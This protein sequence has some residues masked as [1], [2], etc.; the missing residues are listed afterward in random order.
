MLR[1][2]AALLVLGAALACACGTKGAGEASAS[3]SAGEGLCEH[4]VAE[5]LCPKCH[6]ELASVY[7]SNGD[8]CGEH[9][10]PESFCP[11]CHPEAKGRPVEGAP[12][13]KADGGAA[14][15]APKDGTRVQLKSAAIVEGA[16]FE[17][18]KAVK[19]PPKTSARFPARIVYDATRTAE[20]TASSGGILRSVAV[21]LGTKVK[22]GDVLATLDSAEVGGDRSRL[23]AAYRRVKAAQDR[24][25]RVTGLEKDGIVPKRDRVDAE[26]ALDDAKADASVLAAELGVSGASSGSGASYVIKSPLSGVVTRRAAALGKLVDDKEALFQIVDPTVLWAELDVPETMAASIEE[27]SEVVLTFSAVP[28]ESFGGTVSALLPEV[29]A[30]TRTVTARVSVSNPHLRLRANMLGDAAVLGDAPAEGVTVPRAS[31]QTVDRQRFV[32]V[33]KSELVFE[34]RHVTVASREGASALLTSGVQAGEEVVTTGSFLLKTETLK[35]SIGAG[36]C[37]DD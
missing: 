34:V 2:Q 1:R 18:V 26:L 30:H 20:V 29:D 35:D 24:L 11:T 36:C 4:G 3:A 14:A 17:T 27:G 28:S 10:M 37:A 15:K 9:G 7:Q 12:K 31:I 25:E 21:D 22:V 33:R 19:A 32:F 6:P 16:G 5:E 23:A 8:W 13:K